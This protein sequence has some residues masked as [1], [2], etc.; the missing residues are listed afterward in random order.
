MADKAQ[1]TRFLQAGDE[2]SLAQLLPLVVQLL[3]LVYDELPS[4]AAALFS[5]ERANHTLQPPALVHEAYL[6]LT[7]GSDRL[8]WQNRAHFFGIAANSMRQILVNH[9]YEA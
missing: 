2:E 5:R 9:A 7:T 6:R 4:L 8:S 1:I 3:P